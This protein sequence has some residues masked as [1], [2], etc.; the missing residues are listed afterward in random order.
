MK[1]PSWTQLTF[2]ILNGLNYMLG[3]SRGP[4]LPPS[5]MIERYPEVRRVAL[6]A[7]NVD[8]DEVEKNA[9]PDDGDVPPNDGPPSPLRFALVDR[10]RR[11]AR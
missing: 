1:R 2:A 5:R 8:A 6:E 3:G 11:L 7:M 4:A 9:P 10:T